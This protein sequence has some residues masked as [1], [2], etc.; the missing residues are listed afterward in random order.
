LIF[1]RESDTVKVLSKI[2]L[3][4]LQAKLSSIK[5]AHLRGFIIFASISLLLQLKRSR[6]LRKMMRCISNTSLA[7]ILLSMITASVGTLMAKKKI[8]SHHYYQ[9]SN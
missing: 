7:A 5:N 9:I 3:D 6:T 2:L 8:S 1:S 4:I